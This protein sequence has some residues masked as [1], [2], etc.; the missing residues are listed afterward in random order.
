[1]RE[2]T[3]PVEG[4]REASTVEAISAAFV[5]SEAGIFLLGEVEEG[6]GVL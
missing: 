3:W 6:V 1:M 4:R 5:E 2:N